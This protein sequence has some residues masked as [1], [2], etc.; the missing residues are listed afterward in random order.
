MLH[1]N[2]LKLVRQS[3]AKICELDLNVD[4]AE[5]RSVFSLFILS[6]VPFHGLSSA[7]AKVKATQF[8]AIVSLFPVSEISK[9]VIREFKMPL[10]NNQVDGVQADNISQPLLLV[11]VR[12]G[13]FISA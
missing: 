12:S 1:I 2:N 9:K 3:Y 7:P 6:T 8:C 11:N 4:F 13:K 5:V 10:Q